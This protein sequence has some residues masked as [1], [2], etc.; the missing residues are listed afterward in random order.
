MP[1]I[2]VDH[3]PIVLIWKNGSKKEKRWRLNDLLLQKKVTQKC[4][5]DLTEYFTINKTTETTEKTKWEDNK[6]YIR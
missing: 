3:N 5:E 1:K 4:K 2:L 6:S